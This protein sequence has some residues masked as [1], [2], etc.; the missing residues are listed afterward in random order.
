MIASQRNLSS[1][2]Q[3]SGFFCHSEHVEYMYSLADKIHIFL[4]QLTDTTNVV[5]PEGYQIIYTELSDLVNQLTQLSVDMREFYDKAKPQVDQGHVVMGMA[6]FPQDFS[7]ITFV[8][9]LAL[10]ISKVKQ[11]YNPDYPIVEQCI[12]GYMHTVIKLIEAVRHFYGIPFNKNE[13]LKGQYNNFTV[14]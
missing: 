10:W 4:D 3:F 14:H 6:R 5:S 8:A 2:L 12:N 13:L 7:V 11:E 1:D 9:A